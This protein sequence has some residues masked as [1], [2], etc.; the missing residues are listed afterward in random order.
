MW[1][2]QQNQGG[3]TLDEKSYRKFKAFGTWMAK[4]GLQNPAANLVKPKKK[5]SLPRVLS[6]SE[7]ERLLDAIATEPIRERA[8]VYMF[9]DSGLRVSEMAALQRS[10]VDLKSHQVTV[11]NGKGSKDR[12][13]YISPTTSSLL[14][15]YLAT[16]SF[17][18]VWHGETFNGRAGP[19]SDCGI[20]LAL[21][22]LAKR[23]G[24]KALNPHLLRHTCGTELA[25]Q[26]GNLPR[27]TGFPK[28]ISRRSRQ[29]V[30]VGR[31]S[32]RE[33]P[34]ALRGWRP[35]SPFIRRRA[36]HSPAV[37]GFCTGAPGR[38]RTC[39]LLIHGQLRHLPPLLK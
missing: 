29:N 17:S 16:H 15:E 25:A 18:Y 12:V 26:G 8:L 32:N 11:R 13:V 27:L 3:K 38:T 22:R 20:R 30:T 28:R 23:H 31:R 10:E 37:A 36:L 39:N 9:L 1:P 6:P 7:V 2:R 21:G 14:A 24:F 35:H 34:P 19:L 5:R 4:Q 33:R